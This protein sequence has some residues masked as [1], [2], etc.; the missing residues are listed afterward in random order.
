LIHDAAVVLQSK[1]GAR[2][3]NLGDFIL[4][5]YKTAIKPHELLT[6][7]ELKGLNGFR[8]GYIRVTKR[9]AWA[10]S[11]L[12]VAWAIREE[13]GL[14]EEVRVAVGSCTP[15]PFRQK[16]IEDSLRGKPK[17]DETILA[18]VEG[19]ID[20]IKMIS[21]I[22]PSFVYKIPVVKGLLDGILRGSIT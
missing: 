4:A 16:E 11:R 8:E 7:I 1:E 19:I 21:G 6:A 13:N 18:A 15:M 20:E 17:N 9:A 12:S 22:R 10:I 14:Y 3:V 2:R 5:P